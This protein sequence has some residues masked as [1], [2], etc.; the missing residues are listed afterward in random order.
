[1]KR[2][3]FHLLG[4]LLMLTV[5]AGCGNNGNPTRKIDFIPLNSID[6]VPQNPKAAAGTNTRFT[7]IGHYGD[8]STF[9]YTE[10]ITNQVSW[11]SSDTSVLTFSSEP[12][13]AGFATA[14]VPGMATVTATADSISSELS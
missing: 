12:A 7:A 3:W 14:G 9:Q 2:T 13:S 1:M 8:P 4:I 6:I 11:S 10:D 5:P